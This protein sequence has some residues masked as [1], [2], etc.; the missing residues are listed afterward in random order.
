MSNVREVNKPGLEHVTLQLPN[1]VEMIVC[2][3]ME[4]ET[5]DKKRNKLKNVT[6]RSVQLMETGA[7]GP[8]LLLAQRPVVRTVSKKESVFATTLKQNMEA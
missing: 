5:K 7:T 2:C 4:V 6:H 8:L 1:M 3:Q